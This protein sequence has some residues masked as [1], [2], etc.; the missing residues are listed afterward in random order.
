M[1]TQFFDLN[2]MKFSRLAH[3]WLER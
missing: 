2:P 3:I 1:L